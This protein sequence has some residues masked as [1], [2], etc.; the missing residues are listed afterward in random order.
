MPKKTKAIVPE[1]LPKI[2]SEPRFRSGC[3]GRKPNILKLVADC[4][5]PE[6]TVKINEYHNLAMTALAQGAFYALLCG[7]E[8][9]AARAQSEHGQWEEWVADNCPFTSRTARKY[10]AAAEKKFKDI[11]KLAN[12]MDFTV[13][14]SPAQLQP[15]QRNLLVQSLRDATDGETMRQMYLDL[16]IIKADGKKRGGDHGGGKA[17]ADALAGL[18]GLDLEKSLAD[19]QWFDITEKIREFTMQRRRYVHVEEAKLKAGLEGV[20]DCVK[21]IREFLK[22]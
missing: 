5:L 16:G 6:R 22:S 12:V 18:T 8:L 20:N 3:K 15:Q 17:R 1:V 19:E 7:F 10:M 11:P 14:V 13:G 21:A 2:K 9:H 4:S